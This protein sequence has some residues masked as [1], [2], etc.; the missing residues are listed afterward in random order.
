VELDKMALGDRSQFPLWSDVAV[1][2]C[3]GCI[4]ECQFVV[5]RSARV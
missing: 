5:F 1:I 2:K 4:C 3:T